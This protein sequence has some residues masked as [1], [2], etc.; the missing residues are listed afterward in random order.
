MIDVL[1]AVNDFILAWCGDEARDF[2]RIPDVPTCPDILRQQALTQDQVVRGWQN[3]VSALPADTQRYVVLTLLQ[4]IR[5]GTNVHE[6]ASTGDEGMVETTIAR[7]AEYLVQVDFCCAYPAD[8]EEIARGMA[9]MFEMLARDSLAVDFF[10]PYGFQ[11]CYADSPR[12]IPGFNE[13]EQWEARYSVT[14]HL[15]GWERRSYVAEA[16]GNAIV[17][18]ENV[19]VHHPVKY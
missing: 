4:T 18:I 3:V 1:G 10:S 17:T 7:L 14:L 8:G 9:S 19:D 15:T 11:S 12:P 6:Y 5:H 13:A 2:L 16:F